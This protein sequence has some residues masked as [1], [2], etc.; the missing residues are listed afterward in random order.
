MLMLLR[1]ILQI[2]G[3][4][5]QD[6]RTQ[7]GPNAAS[8]HLTKQLFHVVVHCDCLAHHACIFAK[9]ERYRV[10]TVPCGSPVTWLIS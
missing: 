2:V 1:T 3:H 10:A 7:L 9:A 6:L 5:R 8:R 4:C